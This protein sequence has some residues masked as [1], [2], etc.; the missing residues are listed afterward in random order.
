MT[1]IDIRAQ[2]TYLLARWRRCLQPHVQLVHKPGDYL[3][4][5]LSINSNINGITCII[6]SE[7]Y[8]CDD[9]SCT[10]THKIVLYFSEIEVQ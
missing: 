7:M 5:S 3:V 10:V 8:A 4:L 2:V 1:N 9:R 6:N